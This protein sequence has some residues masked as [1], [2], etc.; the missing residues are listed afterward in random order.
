MTAAGPSIY[1]DLLIARFDTP[2]AGASPLLPSFPLL[3]P[4]RGLSNVTPAAKPDL[5]EVGSRGQPPRPTA[6]TT[7][8]RTARYRH[9]VRDR[10]C[11]KEDS[12]SDRCDEPGMDGGGV[13]VL[14]VLAAVFGLGF[15]AGALVF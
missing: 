6:Q 14:L 9:P 10:A 7:R 12:M 15:L 13:I 11:Q 8:D 3:P 2:L 1:A 5:T 4:A